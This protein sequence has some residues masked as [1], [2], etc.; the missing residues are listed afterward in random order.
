MFF[1]RG[2]IVL[3]CIAIVNITRFRITK[4]QNLTRLD[5]H[6]A[7]WHRMGNLKTTT[8]YAHLHIPID[9]THLKQ[10]QQFMKTINARFQ[11]LQIPEEWPAEH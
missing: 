8:S 1:H 11:I 9:T 5:N 7:L 6:G 10:R 3:L 4:S 2:I